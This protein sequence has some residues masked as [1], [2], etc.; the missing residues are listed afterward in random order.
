MEA[1]EV[2]RAAK[3]EKPSSE[4]HPEHGDC[5]EQAEAS[6]SEDA[7]HAPEGSEVVLMSGTLW[8]KSV[9]MKRW[10]KRY[11]ELTPRR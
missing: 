1:S 5:G 3:P 8:K 6:C 11:F 7:E 2:E 10:N 4:E 9:Y